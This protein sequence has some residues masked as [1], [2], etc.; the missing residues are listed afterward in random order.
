MKQLKLFKI[1]EQTTGSLKSIAAEIR[2]LRRGAADDLIRIGRLLIAARAKVKH[3]QWGRWLR[4]EFAWSQ[5][6]AERFVAVTKMV[7]EGKIK[8]RAVRDSRCDIPLRIGAAF[9]L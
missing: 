3:G 1:D 5:D 7:D 9:D 4:D 6:T 8:I 2:S